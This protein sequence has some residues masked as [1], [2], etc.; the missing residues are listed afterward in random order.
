MILVTWSSFFEPMGS[1]PDFYWFNDK[2]GCRLSNFY[3]TVLTS[4]IE[5]QIIARSSA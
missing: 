1:I 4:S 2:K 3:M 5:P